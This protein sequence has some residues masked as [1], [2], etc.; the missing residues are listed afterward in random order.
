MRHKQLVHR[1]LKYYCDQCDSKFSQKDNLSTHVKIVH[2]GVKKY[3]C[4]QCDYRATRQKY[5]KHH[6]EKAHKGV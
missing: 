1:E 3:A 5:V 4:D 2:D 6:I